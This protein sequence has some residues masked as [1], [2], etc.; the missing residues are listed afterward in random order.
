MPERHEARETTRWPERWSTRSTPA[1]SSE[2]VKMITE[3]QGLS[4]LAWLMTREVP[5]SLCT[6][7]PIDPDTVRTGLRSPRSLSTRAQIQTSPWREAGT[8]RRRC[9]GQ[10]VATTSRWPELSSMATPTSRRWV[11]PLHMGRHWMTPWVAGVGRCPVCW[12]STERALASGK[13][14]IAELLLDLGVDVNGSPSW[15]DG[16]PL[17]AADSQDT[18]REALVKWLRG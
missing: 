8:P 9:I 3:D 18:G 15:G 6:P 2:W 16:T 14:R 17:E 4:Q 13:R 7:R 5:P 10:Q 12:P 11:H 1:T